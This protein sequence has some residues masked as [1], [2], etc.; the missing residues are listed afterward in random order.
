LLDAESLNLIHRYT[1]NESVAQ[2]VV[3]SGNGRRLAVLH[4]SGKVSVVGTPK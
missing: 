4:A 3:F 2:A 1:F